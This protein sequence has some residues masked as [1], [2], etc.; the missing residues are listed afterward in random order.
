V[1]YPLHNEWSTP[2]SV[3]TVRGWVDSFNSDEA[4]NLL[5]TGQGRA[6]TDLIRERLDRFELERGDA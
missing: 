6:L 3:R 1:G 4:I 2:R 5:E